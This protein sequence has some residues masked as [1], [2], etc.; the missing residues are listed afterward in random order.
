[1]HVIHLDYFKEIHSMHNDTGI[2]SRSMVLLVNGPA[3]LI[4]MNKYEM[5]MF[6]NQQ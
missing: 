5:E 1:M 3:M 4:T 2:S 6:V